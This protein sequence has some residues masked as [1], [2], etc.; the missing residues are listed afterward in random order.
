MQNFRT[1]QKSTRKPIQKIKISLKVGKCINVQKGYFS[2]EVSSETKDLNIRYFRD[3]NYEQGS[4]LKKHWALLFVYIKNKYITYMEHNQKI[5]VAHYEN[6]LG[7]RHQVIRLVWGIVW[8]LGTWF[9]PRSM[10]MPWKRTLLR[11]FGAHIAS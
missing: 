6:H 10:G 5:D 2:A 3:N 9:L 11:M 8:P 1:I 7:M 4:M